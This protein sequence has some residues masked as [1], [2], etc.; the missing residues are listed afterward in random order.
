MQSYWCQAPPSW[1]LPKYQ[2]PW[3]TLFSGLR[4]SFITLNLLCLC[5]T[6]LTALHCS[7]QW[8]NERFSLLVLCNYCRKLLYSEKL[9]LFGIVKLG[10]FFFH[11]LSETVDEEDY[12]D[13]G[14]APPPMGK[15]FSKDVKCP[16]VPLGIEDI[17]A[18]K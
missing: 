13:L 17:I 10:C 15:K 7:F 8:S 3:K 9:A 11:Q 2:L 6:A 14:G 16:A 18:L 4:F 12:E 5:W 1:C